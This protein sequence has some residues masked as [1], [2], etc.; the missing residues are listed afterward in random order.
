[1]TRGLI[2]SWDDAE[3]KERRFRKRDEKPNLGRFLPI[4][5]LAAHTRRLAESAPLVQESRHNLQAIPLIRLGWELAI[6]AKWV[7]RAAAL[8]DLMGIRGAG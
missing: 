7:A 3:G 4:H 6:T 1:M 5:G 2:K 8:A